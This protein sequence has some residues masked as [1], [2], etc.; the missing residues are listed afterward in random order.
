MY[1]TAITAYPFSYS[2]V[3]PTFRTAGGIAPTARANLG[4]ESFADFFIPCAFSNGFVRKHCSEAR[5]GRIK[6]GLG[7]PGFGQ[8]CGVDV[9]YRDVI[10]F[11]NDAVREFVQGIPARIGD[12]GVN[13]LHKPFFVC[14]LGL[15]KFSFKFSVMALVGDLFSGGK[16]G[17]VFQ[18]EIDT[19]SDHG[20]S[21]RFF[22]DFDH[23]IQKPIA[24]AVPTEIC[25]VLDL[26]FR[27]GT[28]IEHSESVS[29][30]AESVS[31]AVKIAALERYPSERFFAAPTE[32]RAVELLSGFR[33]LLANR[34]DGPGVNPEFYRRSGGEFVEI[35]SGWPFLAPLERLFL[36]VVAVVPDKIH[37]SGLAIE[38]S[39]ERFDPVA[40]DDNHFCRF[41]QSSTAR[42]ISSDTDRPR[43]S[44][45]FF[46]SAKSGSGKKKCVRFICRNTLAT[47]KSIVNGG[48]VWPP[49]VPGIL[50]AGSQQ[51]GGGYKLLWK[52]KV[53]RVQT[54]TTEYPIISPVL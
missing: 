46:R 28:G 2:K 37:R 12:F 32:I 39:G 30:K 47:G 53:N 9:S 19:H 33:V 5:P 42:R 50:G 25:S 18:S 22:L 36:N 38:Q 54:G 34:V 51:R 21:R 8:S 40:I 1:S 7:H 16:R 52:V 24:S 6:N 3:C 20:R 13:R 10:E 15:S 17:K 4:R 44:D 23:D 14:S 29:S 45:S 48:D 11:A 27:E 35:E 31:F 26:A 49:H 41:S 43:V